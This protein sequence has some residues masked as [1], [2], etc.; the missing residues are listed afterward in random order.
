MYVKCGVRRRIWVVR[1]INEQV[2]FYSYRCE[3]LKVE[4]VQTFNL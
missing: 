1:E 4:W 2:C 3:V